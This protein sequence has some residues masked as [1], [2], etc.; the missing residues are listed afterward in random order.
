MKK[1]FCL[2]SVVLVCSGCTYAIV[3]TTYIKSDIGFARLP[4]SHFSYPNSN[5]IPLGQVTGSSHK[6]GSLSDFPR[7]DQ[8]TIE[9]IDNAI[10]SKPGADMLINATTSGVLTTTTTTTTN[11][12]IDGYSGKQLDSNLDIK[13][14]LDFTVTGTAVKMEVGEQILK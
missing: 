5:V 9:A 10:H 7:I 11:N 8:A 1:H 14:D 2:I 13:Y 12:K 3:D 6:T 4:Q